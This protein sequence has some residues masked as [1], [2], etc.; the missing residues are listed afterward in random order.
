MTRILIIEDENISSSRMKRL[1]T[2][3]DD[4][5]NIEG[6][7]T[8]V[9]DVIEKLQADNDYDIIFSD[10]RLKDRLVFDAFLDVQPKCP[11]VFTTAYEDYALNAFRNNGIA[12]L[13]KPIDTDELL[14]AYKKALQVGI[15]SD[16]SSRLHTVSNE[17]KCHRERILVVKGDELIPLKVTSISFICTEGNNIIAYANDGEHYRL[18]LNMCEL[19]EILNPN[20]FFRLNRQY[21][22]HID[23]IEKISFFFNNKLCVRIKGCKDNPIVVS[24]EKSSV[25]RNWLNM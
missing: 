7:L 25:F 23:S 13:L 3:I 21:I 6:P 4:T 14:I 17:I 2:D 18:T 11:V 1:L 22:V 9:D 8:N 19:E 24:K 20:I 12:Y 5:I 10:I 16:I 15:S